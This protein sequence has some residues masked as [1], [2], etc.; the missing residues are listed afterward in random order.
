MKKVILLFVIS[1]VCESSYSQNWAPV[2]AE[3]HYSESLFW[4]FP[5]SEDYIKLESVK[6]TVFNGVICSKLNKRHIPVC[7]G[8]PYT[9]FMYS[10][11]N[12]VFFWDFQLD[13]FQMLYDFHK[14]TGD[15][16]EIEVYDEDNDIDTLLIVVDS[17][18]IIN[19]N[20]HDRIRQFV[21][22]NFIHESWMPWVQDTMIYNSILIENIGDQFY[23][24]NFLPQFLQVCDGNFPQGLRCYYDEELGLYETGIA[25][26][27]THVEFVGI[28]KNNSSPGRVKLF[29]TFC[30]GKVNVE[31]DLRG[32]LHYQVFDLSGKIVSS[33][34]IVNNEIFL[35]N[36]CMG[37]FIIEIYNED[38]S[39]VF[40]GKVFSK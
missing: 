39:Y 12:Q 40:K 14:T 1:I 3:W 30:N 37:M 17:T 26:S 31:T 7:W 6:D 23:M 4:G 22:Y 21:T 18:D 16:W 5:I 13:K 33:G 29:P 34:T 32:V 8:R 11:D 20:S 2:G 36:T 25:P 19:I 10:D 9:E 24:F 28:D 15:S 38:K 27:C 35:N